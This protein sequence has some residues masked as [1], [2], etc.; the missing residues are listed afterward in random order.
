[1]QPKSKGGALSV[2]FL[3][4]MS[5]VSGA[6]IFIETG[7]YGGQTAYNAS[8]CFKEVYTVELVPKIYQSAKE[9]FKNSKNIHFYCDYSSEFLKQILPSLKNKKIIL[10]LDAHGS[11]GETAMLPG[12]EVL[13][14][15]LAAVKEVGI[16]NLIILIDDIRAYLP[17]PVD[18]MIK[19]S[20]LEINDQYCFKIFGDQA[21]AYL[22]DEKFTVSQVV[23]ACTLS[24]LYHPDSSMTLEQV[25][26]AEKVIGSAAGAER[27]AIFDLS[28][29]FSEGGFFQLWEG[30]IWFRERNYNLAI[31]LFE[32]AIK[33][34]VPKERIIP[35]LES[36][37][38][39]EK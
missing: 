16:T 25:L 3:K 29:K 24:R 22:P 6:S 28:K 34:F 4:M 7:T 5:Y 1:M 20:I 13:F 11:G 23:D 31:K 38:R 30:I 10:F 18:L 19:E 32:D 26:E 37:T 35:Y 15:E 14:N 36:I 2:E 9:R 17:Q 39:Y 12:R 21:I 8:L 27:E 33:M